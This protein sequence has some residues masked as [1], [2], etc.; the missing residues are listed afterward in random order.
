M[1]E[2]ISTEQD[3]HM[4]D[5]FANRESQHVS[6]HT[7]GWVYGF[8]VWVSV[9]KRSDDRSVVV[10]CVSGLSVRNNDPLEACRGVES[11]AQFGARYTVTLAATVRCERSA[12]PRHGLGL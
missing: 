4:V 7:R 5:T 6:S 3:P 8:K 12:D 1:N 11:T 9:E 2:A 10:P